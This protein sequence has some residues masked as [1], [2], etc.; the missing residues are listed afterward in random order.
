M[1]HVNLIKY[2][3]FVI[4]INTSTVAYAF[5]MN[6]LEYVIDTLYN[7]NDIIVSSELV[8]PVQI[9]TLHIENQ[10]HRLNIT[11]KN[12][13]QESGGMSNIENFLAG[14]NLIKKS[15]CEESLIPEREV[16]FYESNF[17]IFKKCDLSL[18]DHEIEAFKKVA[19][20]GEVLHE[21]NERIYDYDDFQLKE[22]GNRIEMIYECGSQT[23]P[24]LGLGYSIG[25]SSTEDYQY[26]YRVG[27]W[28]VY[29][30]KN[31][32]R[33]VFECDSIYNRYNYSTEIN[34]KQANVGYINYH[35]NYN[36]GTYRLWF[37]PNKKDIFYIEMHTDDEILFPSILAQSFNDKLSSYEF[38]KNG[39]LL[40]ILTHE[41]DEVVDKDYYCE[42]FYHVD[43]GFLAK[44]TTLINICETWIISDTT[45]TIL[46]DEYNYS[47]KLLDY[48]VN[49]IWPY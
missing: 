40:K 35:D 17:S 4:C 29:E 10:T 48:L 23:V 14:V 26:G 34:Y 47:D 30:V 2:I 28:N 19:K 18:Q 20:R 38:T 9:F 43:T 5:Y 32:S 24:L 22:Q 8:L 7:K 3:I 36:N 15:S 31:I 11:Y 37:S 49:G 13:N 33:N 1:R 25:Y 41:Y 45:F 6:E 21:Y 27:V 39:E 42:Y 16:M 46:E 12:L 44:K